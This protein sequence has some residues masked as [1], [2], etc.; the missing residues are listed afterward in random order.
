VALTVA[1]HLMILYVPFFNDLFSTQPLSWAEL[2]L[3]LAVASVV[4]WGV[5]LQ[6]LISRHLGKPLVPRPKALAVVALPVASG[7]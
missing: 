1:L 7:A 5:E 6:K 3:T 2:G 4:F